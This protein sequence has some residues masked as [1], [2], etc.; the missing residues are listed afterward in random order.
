VGV[1]ERDGGCAGSER[2]R[3]ARAEV[4]LVGSGWAMGDGRRAMMDARDARSGQ[5][6]GGSR[7][8][9]IAAAMEKARLPKAAA[10][11][12]GM[13]QGRCRD[14]AGIGRV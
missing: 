4:L 14:A 1:W 2:G 13:W 5:A 7:G 12:A 6:G 8:P 9:L 11:G 10:T 3:R